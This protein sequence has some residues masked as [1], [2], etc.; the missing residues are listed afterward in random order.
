MVLNVVLYNKMRVRKS[1][2]AKRSVRP[3]ILVVAGRL[4]AAPVKKYIFFCVGT[5]VARVRAVAG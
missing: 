3:N 4:L 5:V 2:S 1:M